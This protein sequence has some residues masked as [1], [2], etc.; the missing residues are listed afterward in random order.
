[1]LPDVAAMLSSQNYA[2]VV[3]DAEPLQGTFNT[4][5]VGDTS[6]GNL[7]TYVKAFLEQA[8]YQHSYSYPIVLQVPTLNDKS[9][10]V[11]GTTPQTTTG[12]RMLPRLARS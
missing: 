11:R 6:N 10:I 2:Q 3:V 7:A 5:Y 1:M 4:K 8:A 12:V 9:T